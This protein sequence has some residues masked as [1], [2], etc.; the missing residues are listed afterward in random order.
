M[1]VDAGVRWMIGALCQSLV[2]N[3]KHSGL[4]S[5]NVPP[6]EVWEVRIHSTNDAPDPHLIP[7]RE[8]ALRDMRKNHPAN[9]V[10]ELEAPSARK[11]KK[12][13]RVQDGRVADRRGGEP[14]NLQQA[15]QGEGEEVDKRL[16]GGCRRRAARLQDV[17]VAGEIVRARQKSY[18]R[19]QTW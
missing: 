14:G 10:R 16:Q 3:R 7:H 19:E 8:I 6:E 4:G 12:E 2:S 5:M 15:S 1:A 17:R 13:G 9:R 18:G 11:R